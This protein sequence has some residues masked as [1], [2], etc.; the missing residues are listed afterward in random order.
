MADTDLDLGGLAH[1]D[2]EMVVTT[3]R[4]QRWQVPLRTPF[5]N[6]RGPVKTRSG[7]LLR[8]EVGNGLVGWG[9]AAPLDGFSPE[10]LH[11][12]VAALEV[13]AGDVVGRPLTALPAVDSRGGGTARSAATSAALDVV[14]RRADC[15]LATLL[16]W[17]G[18]ARPV[19]ATNVV[20]G[21]VDPVEA[22][23]A[24]EAGV[25]RGHRTVKLKVGHGSVG[26]DVKLV[27]AVRAAVGP[28]IAIRI[29]ANGVWTEPT[30]V[31]TLDRLASFVIEYVEDPVIGA[32]ALAR[33][34]AATTVPIALDEPLRTAAVLDQ[35][36]MERSIDIAVLKPTA[37]GGPVEAM[38]L[39]RRAA[40]SDVGTIVTSFLD[41]AVG[42]AVALAVAAALPDGGAAGLATGDL[43]ATDIAAGHPVVDGAMALGPTVGLGVDP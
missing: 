7:A 36:L 16:A 27:G 37:L 13:W 8:V 17:P 6:A 30:A 1:G 28:D 29:D 35:H 20:V 15:S 2:D 43:L 18:S 4:V 25:S 31:A 24:A 3:A 32:E 12:V 39:A 26:D 11:D 19:V 10:T 34:R 38:A 33:V 5:V 9:E 40:A 41:A 21:S 42:R 22:A 14:A 23:R